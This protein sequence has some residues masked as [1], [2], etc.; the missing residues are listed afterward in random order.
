MKDSY[1]GMCAKC[2]NHQAC[3]APCAFV[4]ALLKVDNK[5]PFQEIF[6]KGDEGQDI[7]I[8]KSK[9]H[10][11]EV[12]E[13]NL[14]QL[15]T[16][17]SDGDGDGWDDDK[18][19]PFTTEAGSPF[20]HYEPTL[21]QT[22]VFIQRFFLGR[23]YDEIADELE[24]NTNTVI[25]MFRNARDRLTEALKFID[26]RNAT[27]KRYKSL[28]ARNAKAFGKLPKRQRWFIMNA[29]CGLTVPEIAKVDETTPIQVNHGIKEVSDRIKAGKAEW[30][31]CTLEDRAAAQA[32][33]D[34]KA[35]RYAKYQT[36][37]AMVS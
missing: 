36:K 27:V 10:R 37:K 21:N 18:K 12:N 32:R 8:C 22:T 30:L 34:K 28:L 9:N 26:D 2:R 11:H 25:S 35:Q 29:I 3:K 1:K 19:T 33:L 5:P 16:V 31:E 4:D 23:P 17:D 6:A 13:S 20:A 14:S 15:G 24:V 7:T